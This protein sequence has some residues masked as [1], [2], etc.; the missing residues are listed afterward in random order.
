MHWLRSH[1]LSTSFLLYGLAALWFLVPALFA[2]SEAAFGAGEQ[3]RGAAAFSANVLPEL[4]LCVILLGVIGA[5]GWWKDTHFTTRVRPLALLFMVPPFALTALVALVP[6]I[7]L[8]AE[9]E[10]LDVAPFPV[11]ALV[12][13]LFM[14]LL[15]GIFEEGLFRGC[16]LHGMRQRMP[17]VMAVIVTAFLFG[18]LHVVNWVDGQPLDITLA[19]MMS[20]AGGGVLYG[21]LVLWTNSIWPSVV[22]HALWDAAITVQE[23]VM[24][25]LPSALQ[26]GELSPSEAAPTLASAIRSPELIY[27]ALLLVALLLRNWF[28]RRGA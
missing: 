22:L 8:L 10:P 2:P 23:E 24:V 27:G 13:V 11:A 21:A 1:P 17:A 7:K 20:A 3:E 4:V 28:R 5:L 14:A 26:H 19:Q 15:V 16:L 18:A 6:Y 25:D 9:G 12:P